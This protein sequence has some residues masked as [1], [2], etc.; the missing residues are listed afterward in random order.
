[1]ANKNLHNAKRAKNDEFYTRIAD[2][3]RECSKYKEQFKDKIIYCNC[4]DARGSMF[5]RYFALNFELFGLKRLITTSYNENGQGTLCVY[6]NDFDIYESDIKV[7][8]LEGDGD[9]RSPECVEFLKQADI[10]VTNPPFSLFRE[11]VAQLIE[12]GKEFLIIGNQNALTYKEIF[13]LVK[14]G[15]IWLGRNFVK[16]F[17]KPDGSTQKFG[18]ICWFTNLET[19][20]YNDSCTLTQTY[21]PQSYPKYDNYDAINVDKIKDIPFGYEGAMGVPITIIDKVCSDGLIHFNTPLLV[22]NEDSKYKI[23]KFRK[24]DDDKDLVVNGVSPYF[25][26]VIQLARD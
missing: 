6:E 8:K 17:T 16:E 9:F 10:V 2:I 21:N 23:I 20:K 13:A 5:F 25:R 18:N 19:K 11:Y 7:A 15:K 24:G 1:M 14:E 12:Y 3:G 26:V 4:D 22:G